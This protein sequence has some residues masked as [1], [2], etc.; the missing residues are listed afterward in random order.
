MET[1]P[2]ESRPPASWPLLHSRRLI[3]AILGLALTASLLLGVCLGQYSVAPAKVWSILASPIGLSISDWTI[4]DE[5]VVTLLRG[6]RVLLAAISG[7]GLA[8]CGAALQGIF[9]NPLA[10]P[11]LLGVSS[12]AG[13]GGAIAILLGASGFVLIAVAF[14]AGMLA[15]LIVGAIARVGGRSDITT[16]ILAGVI[17]GAFFTALVTA[18]QLFADPQNS[19]PAIVFWLMGSFATSSWDRVLIAAPAIV[20]GTLV[21]W[22]MRFRI[23]VLSLGEEEAQ[24]LGVPVERDRWLVCAAA[25]L[26]IGA[27]VAVAGIVGWVGIV[28]PH[29]ARLLVGHDHRNVVPTAC[30]LGAIYLSLMDTLARSLTTAELP[31]GVLTAVIGAPIV[32]VL[33]RRMIRGGE[34]A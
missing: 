12:G 5:R 7:A 9:R 13:F 32:A 23:N 18:V 20:A 33:L 14:A 2:A 29:A 24:S 4:M 26:T 19:L 28:V 3:Y 17:V 6:P 34:Q 8:V 10:S 16:T 30:L 27:A 25:S 31:L 22:A 21:L 15:L 11:E 1:L